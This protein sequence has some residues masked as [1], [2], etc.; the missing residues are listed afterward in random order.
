MK[1]ECAEN[2]FGRVSNAREGSTLAISL[3]NMF[4][5]FSF[6]LVMGTTSTPFQLETL[7]G[8]ILLEVSMGRGLGAPKG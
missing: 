3:D 7:L 1:G 5:D 8:E 6:L 2:I 4:R